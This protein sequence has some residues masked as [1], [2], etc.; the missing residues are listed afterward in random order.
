MLSACGARFFWFVYSL[1][2]L[3]TT[4]QLFCNAVLSELMARD[5][6]AL[7]LCR[8]V[9]VACTTCTKCQDT[10]SALSAGCLHGLLIFHNR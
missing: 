8:L 5:F 1:S 9:T 6:E 2:V 10:A 4:A 3:L 7:E